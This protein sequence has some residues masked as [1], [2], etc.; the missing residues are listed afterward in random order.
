MVVKA[1]SLRV[2]KRCQKTKDE[3]TS[4]AAIKRA[5]QN[6]HSG[7]FGVPLTSIHRVEA[8]GAQVFYRA[9]GEESDL[10]QTL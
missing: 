7:R 10:S 8:D 6:R 9:A 3:V 4:R 5:T 1:E 2:L